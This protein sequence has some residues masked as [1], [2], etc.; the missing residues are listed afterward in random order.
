M[1]IFSDK[2]K[3]ILNKKNI[4]IYKLSKL[5]DYHEGALNAMI[6]SKKSIP[7][8]VKV[9]LLLT[10]DVSKEEFEGWI[11]ADKYT[12]E[13]LKLAIESKKSFPFKRKSILTARIDNI[14]KNINMSRTTLSKKIVYNQS[15][16][17]RM[18]TGKINMS[19]PVLEK[20]SSILGISQNEILSWI[21]ADQYNLQTLET[22]YS[23][24]TS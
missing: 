13:V 24:I 16:L 20:V 8:N 1:S 18:I 7:E 17:N 12:K 10:L 4:S 15:G 21:L 19:K 9:K 14:L 23:C 2:I 6:N 22:A 3:N 11:L 5:I